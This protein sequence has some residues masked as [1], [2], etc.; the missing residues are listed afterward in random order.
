MENDDDMRHD[1]RSLVFLDMDDVLCLDDVHHSGL[2]LKIFEQT[3]PDYPEMWQRL[4]DFGAAENLRQLHAEFKPVYVI[5]S[6]WATYLDRE[7]MCEALTRTQLQ[8]VVQ[9]LHAEWRTPRALSSSRRDEIEGWLEAHREPSQPFIIID[10]SWSG[11]CL[12]HSP[13][14][15]DGHVVLC[16]SGFGFTKKR[17][18]EACR[19]L[20]RQGAVGGSAPRER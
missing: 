20:Q 15:L 1:T 11:T 7:Q 3:I 18:K 19:Q 9:N 10:D 14:A 6:S 2:L 4:V 17:L 12:A 16:R 8:F 5:S 13:L